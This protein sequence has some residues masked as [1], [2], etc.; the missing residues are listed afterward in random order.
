MTAKGRRLALAI[1]SLSLALSAWAQS[2]DVEFI[3]IAKGVWLHRS[4]AMLEGYKVPANG[5]LLATDKSL[6]LIDTAWDDAQT[7]RILDFA[8]T[9]IGR[10]IAACFI[11]HS[12]QDRAGGIRVINMNKIPV[13]MTSMTYRLLTKGAFA[14]AY[15]SVL[16]DSVTIDGLALAVDYFGPAHAPDNITIWD[17][18][19][20]LLFG[21]CMVK[22]LDSRDIGNTAD[23]D[24][25]NWP[26]V[27]VKL[28]DKYPGAKI[29]VPGHGDYGDARLLDHSIG[30][31]RRR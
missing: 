3:P 7:E 5:L 4:Y 23:A 6:V 29:V 26:V 1:L 27:L 14:F 30:L 31:L 9:S 25:A 13:Y 17:G 28:R 20:S 15:K 21:G 18:R 11:T 19:D 10:P 2:F 16:N 8:R 22:S 24:L 12:H